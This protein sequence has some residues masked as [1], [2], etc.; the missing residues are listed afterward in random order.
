MKRERGH[1]CF[2]SVR[3]RTDS[4][5]SSTG[6]PGQFRFTGEQWDANGLEYLRARNYDPAT[7]RFTAAERSWADW[8]VRVTIIVGEE[9]W[10]HDPGGAD[11]LQA[12]CNGLLDAAVEVD[13]LRR[14][15]RVSYEGR[16]DDYFCLD[17]LL[18]RPA[19]NGY[20]PTGIDRPDDI[21]R[22]A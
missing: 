2:R 14:R 22:L 5:S 13:R 7:G 9:H 21:P 15:G 19:T 11:S 17:E 8:T 1:A 6:S 12:L 3:S 10:E 18:R 20:L 4:V 16:P